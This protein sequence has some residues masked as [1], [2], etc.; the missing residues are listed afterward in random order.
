MKHLPLLLISLL[1]IISCEKEEEDTFSL[2]GTWNIASITEF[3][4]KDCTVDTSST[5]TDSTDEDS[6]ESDIGEWSGTITFTD[7]TATAT[8]STTITFATA[9][10]I[11]STP[12]AILTFQGWCEMMGGTM[13][14]NSCT[15]DVGGEFTGEWFEE[16]VCGEASSEYS[17]GK[18][19]MPMSFDFFYTL[20]G[21]K[22]CE[23]GELDEPSQ[24]GTAEV[25]KT[26]ATITMPN[27]EENEC[28]IIELT[29]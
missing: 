21:S 16:N 27:D 23:W 20:D 4:N 10:Y 1:L 18:C 3:D 15:L 17:D 12:P 29:K 8:D 5:A 9:D 7:S 11:F 6:W 14:G 28:E 19:N 22:Y 26:S 13:E 24:C 2:V 25:T